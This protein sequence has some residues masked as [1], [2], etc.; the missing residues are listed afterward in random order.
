MDGQLIANNS[1]LT[2]TSETTPNYGSPTYVTFGA[3]NGGASQYMQGSLDDIHLYNRPLNAA[4]VKALYEGNPSQ[5]ITISAGNSTPCGG[6]K[7]AF[8]ANGTTG[9]SKYQW[10]VDNSNQGTNSKTFDYISVKKT[11][12][13]TTRITVEV[14]DEYPCFPQKPVSVD[15]TITVKYCINPIPNTGSRILIPNAFSPNGDG[16]NDTWEIF[17]TA[18]VPVTGNSDVIVEIYNRWGELIFYSK[19]Y[20]DPWNGTCKNSPVMEGTY[21]YVVRVDNDT[22][23]RGTILVVR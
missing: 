4:E 21:A 2:T 9:T 23:L 3:R 5:K 6:D 13:Y 22:V 10:K 20:P 8:S 12:D 11:E 16:T 1:L 19:G 14:T 15:K 17:S 18:G 7:I